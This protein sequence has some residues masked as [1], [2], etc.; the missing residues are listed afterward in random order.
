[1]LV[2]NH[3]EDEESGLPAMNDDDFFPP[4]TTGRRGTRGLPGTC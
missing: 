1:M 4:R 2:G 3:Y